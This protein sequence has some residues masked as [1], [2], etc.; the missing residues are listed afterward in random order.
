MLLGDG[1]IWEISSRREQ[2]GEKMSGD[3]IAAS[4]M[5]CESQK[6]IP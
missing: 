4:R 5:T 2:A 6:G 3:L 1:E